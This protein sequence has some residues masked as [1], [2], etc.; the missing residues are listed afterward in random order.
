[1]MDRYSRP[2]TD[3]PTTRGSEGPDPIQGY[4]CMHRITMANMVN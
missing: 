4:A 2:D 3:D 1:M